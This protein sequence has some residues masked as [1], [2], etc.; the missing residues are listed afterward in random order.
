MS[1]LPGVTVASLTDWVPLSFNRKTADAYPEGYVPRPHESLEVGR[2][3]VSPRYFETLG[4]PFVEGRDFTL[5]DNDKAPRVLIIDQTAANRYWPGQDP[6]G[7]KLYDLG[8]PVHGGG[9]GEEHEAPVHERAARAHDLHELLP[10]I[11]T[12]R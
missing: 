6:L 4:I 9:G 11:R 1:A 8:P 5:D 3:D 12:G 7:K 2:A 10:G